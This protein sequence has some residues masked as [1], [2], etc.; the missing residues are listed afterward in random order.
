MS[1]PT[2]SRDIQRVTF[3]ENLYN[4]LKKQTA[5]AIVDHKKMQSLAAS[6]L[7]DGLD[8]E[9]C[10]E[11]LMVD[12]LSREAAESYASMSQDKDL[13]VMDEYSFQ[14]EDDTGKIL[15]SHDIGKTI[16]AASTEDAWAKAEEYL[17]N[18]SGIEPQ[19]LISV[20]RVE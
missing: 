7:Q 12:G 19:K 4:S 20:D 10:I 2:T 3:V 9:E 6:Y 18:E 8:E 17:Y 1:R 15:S 11:L 16:R 13:D 5:Q 14:F